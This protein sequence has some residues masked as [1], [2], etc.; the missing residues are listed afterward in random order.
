M[1]AAQDQPSFHFDVDVDLGVL[2][3][4][5]RGFWT[6]ETVERYAA[7]LLAHAAVRA[8]DPPL[9]GVLTDLRA[10]HLHRATVERALVE[11]HRRH[12]P[13]IARLAVVVRSSLEAEQAFRISVAEETRSFATV[14]AAL[15]WLA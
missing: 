6:L 1:P 9:Q 5:L 10:A 8:S 2:C 12:A 14:E 7:A 11:F 4:T 3:V 15:Q 13:P